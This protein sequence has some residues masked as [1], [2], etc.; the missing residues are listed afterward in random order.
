MGLLSSNDGACQ[1]LH[2]ARPFQQATTP[3]ENPFPISQSMCRCNLAPKGLP[4]TCFVRM[5]HKL[6]KG[7]RLRPMSACLCDFSWPHLF[8]TSEDGMK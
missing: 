7:G 5:E 2:W 1:L 4:G 3:H 8:L 6:D